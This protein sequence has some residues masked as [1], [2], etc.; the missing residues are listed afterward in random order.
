MGAF[1]ATGARGRPWPREKLVEEYPR[2]SPGRIPRTVTAITIGAQVVQVDHEWAFGDRRQR[3]KFRC[4]SCN[5]GCKFLYV[6]AGKCTCR[7]CSGL[8]YSSRHRRRFNGGPAVGRLAK[9]RRQLG[10]P[11]WPAALPARPRHNKARAK[12]DRLLPLILKAEAEVRDSLRRVVGDL[13]A[14]AN[15]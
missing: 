9:L 15:R 13:E 11:A 6:V 14:R 4:P 2:A 12:Y 7:T 1:G 5:R 8:D 3:P 10:A